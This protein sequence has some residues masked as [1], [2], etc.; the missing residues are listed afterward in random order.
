MDNMPCEIYCIKTDIQIS[1]DCTREMRFAAGEVH[2]LYWW[3]G[4]WTW[5]SLTIAS[6]H[7]RR[8]WYLSLS[9]PASAG[10]CVMLSYIEA[11]VYKKISPLIAWLFIKIWLKWLMLHILRLGYKSSLVLGEVQ[12]RDTLIFNSMTA[13]GRK[14]WS[15]SLALT[16]S[17]S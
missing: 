11:E 1:I 9:R 5:S 17:R 13:G 6:S 4:T 16:Y 7:V 12:G 14:G 2:L 3:W 8:V 10:N 15:G